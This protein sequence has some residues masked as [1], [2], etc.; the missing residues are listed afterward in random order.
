M[1]FLEN[2]EM[3]KTKESGCYMS[4]CFYVHYDNGVEKWSITAANIKRLE[5]AH[6]K[7]QCRY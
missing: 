4:R 3:K 7:W 1:Q 6:H 2:L 5:A